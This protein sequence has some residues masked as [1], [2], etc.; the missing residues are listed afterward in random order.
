M[1]SI[2][3]SVTIEVAG[4]PASIETDAPAY[5]DPL[6]DTTITVTVFDDEGVRVGITE[7]TVRAIEGGG[8]IEDAGDNKE[9]TVDGQSTFTFFAPSTGTVT[10]RIDAG[11]QSA[12]RL[13]AGRCACGGSAS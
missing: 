7:V 6:S 1:T 9:N 13:A 10:L 11:K 3:A 2:S 4:T 5:V 8:L 12:H